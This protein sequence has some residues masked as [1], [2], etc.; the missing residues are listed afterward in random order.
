MTGRGPCVGIF[1]KVGAFVP[2]DRT[3]LA[4]AAPYGDGLT[5]GTD[6]ADRRLQARALITRLAALDVTSGTAGVRQRLAEL[7]A[8]RVNA[9]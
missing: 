8:D 2:L 6:H 7:V 3:P 5:Q 9:A 1:W 4:Q